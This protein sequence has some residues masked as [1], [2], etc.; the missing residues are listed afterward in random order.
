MKT[1]FNSEPFVFASRL[2]WE[3]TG[4]GV[5]RKVLGFSPQLMM[6]CV[7]FRKGA[8]GY[9][10]SHPHR[11]VTYVESGRFEVEIGGAMEQLAAGDSFIV[12][13]E[14]KHGVKALE[15]GILVDVFTPVREDFLRED[16]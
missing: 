2:E 15:E 4:E 7:E 9:L 8:V 16:R 13:P 11:Q 6:V 3:N 12:G 14:V 5:R 10:H 1:P